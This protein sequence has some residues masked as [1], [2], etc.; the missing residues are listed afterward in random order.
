M[1]RIDKLIKKLMSEQADN[2]FDFDDL[3]KVINHFGFN[4]EIKGSHHTYRIKGKNA[5][6]NIQPL[7]GNKS[8]PYQIKQV[9]KTLQKYFLK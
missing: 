6:I 9:R 7:K 1:S 2:N 8:K 5:F 3:R 4:E